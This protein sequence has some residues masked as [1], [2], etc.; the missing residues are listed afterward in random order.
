MAR[1][2]F[3]D[4]ATSQFFICSVDTPFLDGEYAAFGEVA[5]KDSMQV[6]L[7]LDEDVQS[8]AKTQL[9]VFS[10]ATGKLV[11]LLLPPQNFLP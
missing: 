4:S 6:D 1:T 8:H 11:C 3:K 7:F 5:D 10:F 9:N 2:M